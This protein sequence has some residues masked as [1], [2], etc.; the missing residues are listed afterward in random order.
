MC[1]SLA[2]PPTDVVLFVFVVMQNWYGG[3]G[4]RGGAWEE[5]GGF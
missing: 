1:G 4:E 5:D 2:F 3:G